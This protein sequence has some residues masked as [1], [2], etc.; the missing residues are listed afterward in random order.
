MDFEFDADGF[1]TKRSSDLEDGI[2]AA[3]CPLFAGARNINR[4]CHDLLFSA[5]VRNHDHR[6]VIIATLFMR[7]LDHYQATIILLGRGVIPDAKVT[8]RAL[9]ECIFKMRAV[10]INS[11]SLEIFIKQDLLY[12]LKS[13]NNARNNSYSNI[14]EARSKI[15]DDDIAQL[16][17][18]VK[19][20]GAKEI[21]IVEWS[22]LADM[23]EWYIAH[24]T[25]LSDAIHTPVRELEAY[26][27]LG[28]DSEIKQLRYAPALDDIPLLLLTAAQ[29]LL[30]GASSFDK[31][32]EL[33]FGP[34][35]DAHSRFVEA[36][37][38]SLEEADS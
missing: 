31:T 35:G 38:R 10:S 20:R 36:G 2:R 30:I 22:R 29:C 25:L 34:K 19:R 3:Y 37:F 1:L 17:A 24:Y 11:S 9:V 28:E 32:F 7:C 21:K 18:E 33:G 14:D 13:M 16:K 27:V 12:R 6:A 5:T 15:T 26:L 4:D 23:H 8:L